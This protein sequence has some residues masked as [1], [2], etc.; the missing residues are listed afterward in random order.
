M[1]FNEQIGK[2]IP[3]ISSQIAMTPAEFGLMFNRDKSVKGDGAKYEKLE[4]ELKS[5]LRA[6]IRHKPIELAW[7]VPFK[8]RAALLA[9][10]TVM[11]IEMIGSVLGE[12]ME[13]DTRLIEE[14]AA[15]IEDSGPDP[16]AAIDMLD[17]LLSSSMS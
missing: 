10:H 14:L 7:K 17:S 9:L 12:L 11:P 1:L 15:G 16:L 6:S 3:S 2:C 5:A 4:Q 13:S 8:R